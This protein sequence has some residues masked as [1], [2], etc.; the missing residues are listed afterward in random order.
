MATVA[1]RVEQRLGRAL[2]PAFVASIKIAI[3]HDHGQYVAHLELGD[4]ERSLTSPRCDEL[5]DAVALVVSRVADE[6]ALVHPHGA[7]LHL[8]V[9][10]SVAVDDDDASAAPVIHRELDEADSTHRVGARRP[11][12]RG[13]RHRHRAR[14]RTR[15][16]GRAQPAPSQR[17]RRALRDQ[18]VVVRRRR[19]RGVARRRRPR[20]H[21]RARRLAVRAP[22]VA[23]V[24][25]RRG[26]LD[27]T[28]RAPGSRSI[29][30]AP[31]AGSP[32]ARGSA[33]RGR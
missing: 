21:G 33:S 27:G 17:A 9:A 24:A 16:G 19:S 25:Q 23:G 1:A 5:A 31:A 22:A 8:A 6:R 32:R 15:R 7:A 10:P 13:Q 3:S 4:D 18:V 20:R 29:R 28:A 11:G 2:D 26:R 14:G 12:R 30:A